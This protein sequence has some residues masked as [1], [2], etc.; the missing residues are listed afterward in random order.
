MANR[1]DTRHNIMIVDSQPATST[2]E[3]DLRPGQRGLILHATWVGARGGR[4]RWLALWAEAQQPRPKR[5]ISRRATNTSPEQEPQR[6]PHP[7]C[8]KPD[9]LYDALD[10]L[11]RTA[12]PNKRPRTTC[13]PTR[14][15]ILLPTV[16]ERPLPSPETVGRGW[17]RETPDGRPATLSLWRVHAL[18]LD[19]AHASAL[20][21]ILPSAPGA[22]ATTLRRADAYDQS[23][24]PAM[25]LGADLRYWAAA[26][27]FAIAMI[28]RQRY[29]PG[30]REQTVATDY[31]YSYTY[32]IETKSEWNI[33]PFSDYERERFEMLAAA[34]PDSARSAYLPGDARDIGPTPAR[35]ALLKDFCDTT[36]T[37]LLT[38]W[39]RRLDLRLNERDAETAKHAGSFLSGFPYGFGFPFQR[40]SLTGQWLRSL[41]ALDHSMYLSGADTRK[42]LD[43]VARWQA[44]VYAERDIPFRLCLRLSDPEALQPSDSDALEDD[45]PSADGATAMDQE[46]RAEPLSPRLRLLDEVPLSAPA[47]RRVVIEDDDTPGWR[48]DYL[49]QARDDPSLLIPVA[50]VWRERSDAADLLQ[51]RFEQP[52]AHVLGW[53]GQAAH[54]FPPMQSSLRLA[55]PD[56]C[57]LTGAQAYQFLREAALPLEEAGIAVRVPSWWKRAP[58]RPT[59]RLEVRQPPHAS[60]G[61]LGLDAVLSFDWKVAIGGE[62]LSEADLD[63]LVALKQPLVRL[64][65]QWVELRREDMD[66]MLRALSGHGKRGLSLGEA[67]RVSMTGQTE[68]GGIEVE[69]VRADAWINDLLSRIRGADTLTEA[70]PPAGLLAELRPYQRKGL[71]WLSFLTRYGLGACLAD[72]MGLGKTLQFLALLLRLK[73][74]GA[75]TGPALLVCPTS[76]VGNWT[77]EAR[78]FAPD[79]RVFTHHGADRIGRADTE[80][81]STQAAGHDL[82][83]TTY[84]LLHRDAEALATVAWSIIALDEAQNIKNSET[85][86]SRAARALSA[87]MRVALTGTP[88]E[89]R[90]AELWSIMHFLNPGYLGSQRHF[91]ERFAYPI[92]QQHDARAS[93]QLQALVRP[94]VLRRLKTDRSVIQDL[95]DKVEMREYCSLTREQATLYEAVVRDGLRQ[96]DAFGD[97]M[98]RRGAVLAMLSKLKQICN[99][100]A[101]FLNDGSALAGRSGKLARLEDLV[102]ELLDEGDRALIF[103]QFTVMGERLREYLDERFKIKTLYLHGGTPRAHRERMIEQFQSDDGPPLFLLS[104]KAGGTGLNLTHANHVIHFDRWWNP[105]VETQATDR[106]FRI[107]QTR[108]VQVRKFVCAGTLEERIDEMIEQKRALAEGIFGSGEGW[109][110]ELSTAELREIFRLRDDAVAR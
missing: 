68:E 73:E 60:S 99:H 91:H 79:L 15:D 26:T 61:L 63:R 62:E 98:S 85:K 8:A 37:S 54:L 58:V 50:D 31:S 83:L 39:M 12:R 94:F 22:E 81:F 56:G 86:Q 69:E 1:G 29:L 89:N 20:L 46:E 110:T 100:P 87:P 78:R 88:V 109:L 32:A 57:D 75:L 25:P 17:E 42:L 3:P 55:R 24:A 95:P 18:L 105:A 82:V 107:G 4:S 92:E 35:E 108:N 34:M 7:W 48:L 97:P 53:L 6:R 101:H 59:L 74:Q 47:S 49:L 66:A 13:T 51:R 19:P 27:R 44:Q 11:W 90:L 67:L 38:T 9:E 96:L 41:T 10:R 93:A 5:R 45:E 21:A 16:D 36:I 14:M 40:E 106:A 102:E 103:T 72:D 80:S 23:A 84:S 52:Y 30:V 104:L 64:R 71:D 43:G 76:V 33:V 77:H 28:A 65:G 2:A 70:P